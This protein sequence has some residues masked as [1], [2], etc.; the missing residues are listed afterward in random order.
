MDAENLPVE[1]SMEDKV[2]EILILL[3]EKVLEASKVM[4]QMQSSEYGD[5]SDS[6]RKV[7]CIFMYENIELSNIEF[8][9]EDASE[10]DLAIQNRKNVRLARC[11]QEAHAAIG[12]K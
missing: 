4:K 9:K 8:K 12:V 2:L 7:D 11:L 6:G 1:A 3:G 10:R 5:I